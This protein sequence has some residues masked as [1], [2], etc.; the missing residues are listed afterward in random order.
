[1]PIAAMIIQMA[2]SRSREYQADETGA[3]IFAMTHWPWLRHLKNYIIML[4]EII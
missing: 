3:R 1:M 4:H 2:I